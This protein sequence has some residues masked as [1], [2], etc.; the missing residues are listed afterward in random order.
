MPRKRTRPQREMMELILGVAREDERIRAVILN[1]SRAN[2]CAKKD[3]FQDYDVVYVVTGTVGFIEDRKWIRRF[4]EMLILQTPDDMGDWLPSQDAA[5]PRDRYTWLMQ[6]QDGNRIDLSIVHI[7]ARARLLEDSLRVLLLDKDA[8]FPPFPPPDDRSYHIHPPTAKQYDDCCNEFLWV[9]PYVAKGLWRDEPTYVRH[10]METILR[11]QLMQMLA[12]HAGMAHGF[13]ISTGTYDKR[14][15]DHLD[16]ALWRMLAMT[17][18]DCSQEN[19][20]DALLDMGCLFRRAASD[21][22]NGMGSVFFEVQ[23]AIYEKHGTARTRHFG[24]I[25]AK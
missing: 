7:D 19:C 18:A 20:W 17:W 12:W 10:T 3:A 2:P 22:A 5:A 21:V 23:E 6:F 9:S 14:L 4:G 24:P 16:P 15:G 25:G 11:P 13:A 8:L 1:G